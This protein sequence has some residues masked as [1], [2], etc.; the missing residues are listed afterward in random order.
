MTR[1]PG[2]PPADRRDAV[3]RRLLTLAAEDI[4]G[5]L[6]GEGRAG[7]TPF[8]QVLS[9]LDPVAILTRAG[10]S[11]DRRTIT[12]RWGSVE[13]FRTD[14]AVWA[15]SKLDRAAEPP[16]VR[17]A[18]DLADTGE[19][20]TVVDATIRTADTLLHE[21]VADPRSYLIAHLAPLLSSNADGADAV[22]DGL[23]AE[24]DKWTA[25][26][27]AL[28]E[29]TGSRL[30]AGWS[31]HR[32]ALALQAMIS[33]FIIHQRVQPDDYDYAR[34]SSYDKLSLFADSVLT[35]IIGV[36]DFSD[37][38]RTSRQELLDRWGLS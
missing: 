13:A 21:L 20:T 26:Y 18:G 19:P 37:E 35:F 15:L 17:M 12:S 24:Q 8:P 34:S 31:P 7:A 30:R 22:V 9:H 36:I 11:P 28:M 29:V 16:P 27:A 6:A 5:F 25:T 32:L 14:A 38:R 4:D 2:R 33:G 10:Y 1:G 23:R 3:A